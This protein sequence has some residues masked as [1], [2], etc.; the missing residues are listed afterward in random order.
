MIRK[1]CM[2]MGDKIP[3][4]PNLCKQFD[5]SRMTMR[6]AIDPPVLEG[7]TLTPLQGWC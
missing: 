3:T 1:G 6:K 5:S 4:E 2:E 7:L